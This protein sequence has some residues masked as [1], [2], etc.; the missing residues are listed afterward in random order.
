ML[1]PLHTL[2]HKQDLLCMP[3]AACQQ[4]HRSPSSVSCSRHLLTADV[5]HATAVPSTDA[6]PHDNVPFV[7]REGI[8]NIAM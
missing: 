3:G 2:A 4:P 8:R 5:V 7:A 1:S 6:L